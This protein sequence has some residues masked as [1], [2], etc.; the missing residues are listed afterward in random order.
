MF[1]ASS[2]SISNAS[3]T[4]ISTPCSFIKMNR[5]D[6]STAACFFALFSFKSSK[7]FFGSIWLMPTYVR[8]L[9]FALF[10]L[11]RILC[12][13]ISCSFECVK[14]I[15]LPVVDKD[16]LPLDQLLLHPQ[17]FFYHKRCLQTRQSLWHFNF[18]KLCSPL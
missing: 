13:L 14:F 6:I 12:F 1:E 3:A 15:S 17:V 5:I 16:R 4:S 9:M 7:F 10:K 2:L 11:I 18:F 8:R